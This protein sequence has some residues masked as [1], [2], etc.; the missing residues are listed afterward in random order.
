MKDLET[1]W[2]GGPVFRQ[3]AHVRL[4]TDTVLLADFVPAG[5]CR[6]G[7]ELGC[8]SGAALLLLLAR[9]ERLH[10][11]GL[12]LLPEAAALARENL[13]ANALEN[14]GEIV[15]GDLRRHRALFPAGAFDLVVANPPYYPVGSGAVSP[16]PARAAA[17]GELTCTLGEV[18]AAAAWLCRTGGRVCLVH[19]PERLAELLCALSACGI[20]P[21]RLRTVA[22]RAECAPSLVLVE[23]RRGARPGL[24][25]EAPLVLQD[26]HGG[27]SEELR[28]IYR[29]KSNGL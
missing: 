29:R 8:A 16:D 25:I 19:K 24:R 27:E 10:M 4:G 9:E 28:R 5:R 26:E 13:A 3:A 20:E 18:C 21:K 6:R 23:G 12:E 14:R 2:E 15:C 11:T 7:I 22:R 17:R 1:L